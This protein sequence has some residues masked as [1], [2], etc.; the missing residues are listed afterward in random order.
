MC[1]I[2]SP[3][4]EVLVH[5][6]EHSPHSPPS[7]H[8]P[9]RSYPLNLS[10][11]MCRNHV[12]GLQPLKA[13]VWS[14]RN[15]DY[16]IWCFQLDSDKSHTDHSQTFS[17]IRMELQANMGLRNLPI[18]L[19]DVAKLI[20]YWGWCV[21]VFGNSRYYFKHNVQHSIRW[22][23]NPVDCKSAICRCGKW[24]LHCA[25]HLPFQTWNII[26][27]NRHSPSTM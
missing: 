17:F 6:T 13:V 14:L 11:Y 19:L 23:I 15:C 20:V 5:C 12:A 16:E 3:L 9:I 21:V 2:W 10:I 8:I 24:T 7:N 26:W 22:H 18:S 1:G 4:F 27:P 25:P